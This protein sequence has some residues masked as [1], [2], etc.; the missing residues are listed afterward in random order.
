[1]TKIEIT[2]LREE[3]GELF[4]QW[5]NTYFSKYLGH[6]DIEIPRMEVMND[7]EKT[8]I[9]GLITHQKFIRLLKKW[10]Q[11]MEFEFNP[12]SLTNCSGRI[13]RKVEGEPIELIYINTKP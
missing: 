3:I 12:Q 10:C 13:I 11:L 4:E 6:L 5:A 8:K 2:Q 1:M 9:H 7:F